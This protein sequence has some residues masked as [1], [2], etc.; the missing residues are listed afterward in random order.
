MGLGC[1][2]RAVLSRALRHPQWHS[3]VLL[4]AL[5]HTCMLGYTYTSV[6]M[7]KVYLWISNN[8]YL[9]TFYICVYRQM[10]INKQLNQYVFFKLIFLKSQRCFSVKKPSL[11]LLLSQPLRVIVRSHLGALYLSL[12]KLRTKL[13]IE[14]EDYQLQKARNKASSR[15]KVHNQVG[16]LGAAI[17]NSSTQY[18]G[19]QLHKRKIIA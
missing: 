10:W 18:F 7:Y 15:K 11:V 3:R 1:P 2:W 17:K 6:Y 13:S 16:F 4:M 8:A 12:Y 9:Y 14:H 5:P 19:T